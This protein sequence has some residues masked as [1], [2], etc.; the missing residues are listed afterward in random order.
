M[1]LRVERFA[2]PAEE[3]DAFASA[4]AGCTHAHRY[5]WKAIVERVYGHDCPFLCARGPDGGLRAVLPLVDVRAPLLGRSFVS[6]PYLSHGGPLG[7]PDAVR[8]V[9]AHAARRAAEARA[10]LLELR[11]GEAPEAGLERVDEKIT[12][13]LPLR[14]GAD[15]V[16]ARFPAKVRSQV[17][18]PQKAG[19][20]MRF[21][22]GEREPFFAVFARAMR[23]LGTP[24]HPRAFFAAVAAGLGADAWFGCVYLDGRP[25]AA[26]CALRHGDSVELVWAGAV[27][28]A[29]A[30]APNMLLYAGFIRR[31]AD[32]GASSFDFGRC[33][34]G[35]GTHRFKRQWGAADVPLPWHRA[36]RRPGAPA[37]PRADRGAFA[38]GARL[39]RRLP[40]PLATWLGPPIRGG[41]SL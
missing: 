36:V 30:A 16:F 28:E 8:A 21:G 18:R 1:G 35:S 6:L 5:A 11:T 41:I 14:G 39:W 7:E 12:C 33:T 29:S 15:A 31:A 17:R 2:G 9:V 27:R 38:L 4:H 26:G 40:L 22:A 37:Q 25:A 13:V 23:D 3:W 32:E 10:D 34:P 19:A 20:V 24:T